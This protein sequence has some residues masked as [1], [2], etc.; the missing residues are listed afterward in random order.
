MSVDVSPE[1]LSSVIGKIYDSAIDPELWP[2]TLEDICG[3][4]GATLGLIGTFDAREKTMRWTP[5]WGGDPYWMKLLHDK[6]TALMPFWSIM[7]QYAIGEV[8]DTRDMVRRIG[9]NEEEIRKLPFFKEWA[10][11]AGYYD[12]AATVVMRND[13]RIASFNLHTPPTRGPIG[14]DDIAILN[15]INPHVRRAV[16]IG[17]LLGMQSLASGAFEATLNSLTAAVVLVDVTG[18]IL[19]SN[20]AAQKT[21]GTSGL[22]LSQSGLLGAHD[23]SA[24]TALKDAIARAAANESEMGYGGIGVPLRSMQSG[25]PFAHAIAHV[26][27]LKSGTLRPGLSLGAVAAVF[28]T[29]IVGAP[30][31][32][33]ETLTA[34]YDLTPTEARVMIEIASGKNRAAAALSLGIADSTVK[35]HLTRVFEKT[36]TSEQSELAKL[37]A[38][39]TSPASARSGN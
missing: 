19:H 15:L 6:Y 35:T 33:L 13:H 25:A 11:P 37:V 14:P 26:L 28:V 5:R 2:T 30:P 31:P 16:M 8:A 17:D 32:P 10:E 3:L 29:P 34:L 4:I 36:G 39:L 1:R 18:R 9:G 12:V 23:P 27:P 22:I 20:Y 21:F 7:P 38:S 24:A